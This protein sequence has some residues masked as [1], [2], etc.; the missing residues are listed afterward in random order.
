M[1]F[2]WELFDRGKYGLKRNDMGRW[3]YLVAH[4]FEGLDESKET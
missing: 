1:E 3:H 2:C 4:V